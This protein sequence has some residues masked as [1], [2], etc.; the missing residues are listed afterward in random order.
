MVEERRVQIGVL[1]ALG[2]GKV[3]IAGKYLVYAGLSSLSGSIVG[4]FLGYW[5]FPTVIIKTYTMMYDEFPIVL[6]F[7][8]K[9]A[10]LASSVAVLCMC[11][12]VFGRAL[13]H[14]QVFPRSLCVRNR[15]Q[16][17]AKK[18]SLNG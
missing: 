4:V 5:I 7:N 1:K 9:Y 17:A 3:A 14:F 8:V 11:N 2:Y 16:K 18:Y 12:Y 15:P 6:E 10:V 13:R